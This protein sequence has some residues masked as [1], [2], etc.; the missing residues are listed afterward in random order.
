MAKE[1]FVYAETKSKFL[2]QKLVGKIDYSQIGII[3]ETGEFWFQDTFYPLIDVAKVAFSGSYIDLED[4]PTI[5]PAITENTVSGW[6]FTKNNGTITEVKMNGKSN[7]TSGVVDLGT[8]LTEHQDISGKVDKVQGKGLSTNDFTS[9]LKS[10]LE[11]LEN[12]DDTKLQE[13]LKAL[14]QEVTLIVSKNSKDSIESFEEIIEFLRGFKDEEN[15]HDIVS[16]KMDKPSQTAMLG[17]PNKV[18]TWNGSVAMMSLPIA[19]GLDDWGKTDSPDG[20][21]VTDQQVQAKIDSMANK[22]EVVD[23]ANDLTGVLEATAEEFTFRPSAGDKSIR[24]E[25]AVIKKIKGNTIVARYADNTSEVLPM[26][27]IGIETIGFN[28][29]NGEYAEVIGG[30]AYYLGGT[31]ST[32]YFSTVKGGDRVEITADSDG[33]YTPPANGYIYATGNDICINLSHS[34]VRNGEYEPYKKNIRLLPEIRKYFPDGMNGNA[35]VWDEIN[36]EKAIK[37]W[38]IVDL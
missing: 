19:D 20:Y 24:D 21:L 2:S 38:G 35:N 16:L 27:T 12:Y 29:Y 28:A 7:G 4:K 36:S 34:G 25:S 17:L 18:M 11:S 26:R 5:P 33:I 9:E 23:F 22:S 8:V 31:I 1:L 37:R 13:T 6:G 32:A 15:L 30:Q 10:K 14:R 3:A